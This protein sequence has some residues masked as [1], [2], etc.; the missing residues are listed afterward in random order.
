M[1]P[2]QVPGTDGQSSIAVDSST[3][4]RATAT[5]A[6]T[7]PDRETEL[8]ILENVCRSAREN[9]VSNFRLFN[10]K[11]RDIGITGNEQFFENVVDDNREHIH[12]Y[13][14]IKGGNETAHEVEVVHSALLVDSLLGSYEDRVVIIDGGDQKARPVVQALSGI[15]DVVPSVTYCLQSE[16]YYPQS[17]LADLVGYYVSYLIENDLYDYT[18]PFFHAPYAEQTEDRWGAAFSGMKSRK[19]EYRVLDIAEMRGDTPRDR[20]KCWYHGGMARHGGEK[21]TTNSLTPLLRLAS[22]KGHSNLHAELERL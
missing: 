16:S 6:V 7:V 17:L 2:F 4:D 8:D 19:Q 9:G 11:G 20:A 1:R 5:V 14:H 15:R 13:H 10:R 3:R 12:G 21:P 22:K 18:D